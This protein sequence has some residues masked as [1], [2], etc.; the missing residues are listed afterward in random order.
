MDLV[1]RTAV[2]NKD[3][4]PY[5]L[6]QDELEPAIA[7]HVPSITRYRV[8]RSR[9]ILAVLSTNT[10]LIYV[11]K[12]HAVTQLATVRLLESPIPALQTSEIQGLKPTLEDL[13]GNNP[14]GHPP[15]SAKAMELPLISQEEQAEYR[16][17]DPMDLNP[18]ESTPNTVV[19]AIIHAT[20]AA[21]QELRTL[22]SAL[23]TPEATQWLE[24]AIAEFTQLLLAGAIRFLP[25]KGLPKPSPALLALAIQHGFDPTIIQAIQVL[26]S[27][28][29]LKQAPRQWQQKLFELLKSLGYK[30]LLKEK[31]NSIYSIEDKCLAT[32]FLRA[33]IQRDK[34]KRTLL[35]SQG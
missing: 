30:A 33:E 34:A 27:L 2:T 20:T 3:L 35:E 23:K 14:P 22:F 18:P 17:L 10:Y 28:Y 31:I 16:V 26:H 19:Q 13:P 4:T 8:I 11:L 21:L 1:N 29:G 12:R 5:Q 24:A 6:L 15:T 9:R 32:W 25:A 7:P